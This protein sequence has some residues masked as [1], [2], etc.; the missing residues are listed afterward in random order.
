MSR[1]GS[2]LTLRYLKSGVAN[3]P[4]L[5]GRQVSLCPET[6]KLIH[7]YCVQMFTRMTIPGNNLT[8]L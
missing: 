8:L 2:K 1:L 3:G 7:C 5:R 4:I 6:A